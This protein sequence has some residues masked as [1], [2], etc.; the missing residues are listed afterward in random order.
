MGDVHLIEASP[1]Q[2][3]EGLFLQ[4]EP[5]TRKSCAATIRLPRAVFTNHP[6]LAWH[7]GMV[8]QRV[9][10]PLLGSLY[11]PRQLPYVS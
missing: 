7:G 9:R 3:I 4:V 5:L 2:V 10:L 11:S 1:K 8:G 6:V